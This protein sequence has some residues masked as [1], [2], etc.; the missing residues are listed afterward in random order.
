M[1]DSQLDAT[2]AQAINEVYLKV[3]QSFSNQKGIVP[4]FELLKAFSLPVVELPNL[5]YRVIADF[6]REET[7]RPANIAQPD[8]RELAGFLYVAQYFNHLWGFIFLRQDDNIGRRR[9]SAAHELGHYILHFWPFLQQHKLEGEN[10]ILTEGL[11]QT[12]K[13]DEEIWQGR[14]VFSSAGKEVLTTPTKSVAQMEQEAD[15]FAAELLMP[16][17]LCRQLVQDTLHRMV[18]KPEVI[19]KRL[20]ADLLVS[21][22]AMRVRLKTLNLPNSLSN[23][24][25]P[26]SGRLN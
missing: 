26:G 19:A 18:N 8:E 6:L 25:L 4:L 17:P 5:S 3:G 22:A 24:S 15:R 14:P 13:G 1:A 9:F 20:A 23:N 10:L 2:I 7:G 12:E 16:A 11:S 21:P